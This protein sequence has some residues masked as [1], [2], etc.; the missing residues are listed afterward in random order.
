MKD[1]CKKKENRNNLRLKREAKKKEN[2]RNWRYLLEFKLLSGLFRWFFLLQLSFSLHQ[3]LSLVRWLRKD[4]I[5]AF[6]F[7]SLL[8]NWNR[9][10]HQ[11][12][13]PIAPCFWCIHFKLLYICLFVFFYL[14]KCCYCCCS[15]GGCSS[16]QCAVVVVLL[17]LFFLFL[18]KPFNNTYG[19]ETLRMFPLNFCSQNFCSLTSAAGRTHIWNEWIKKNLTFAY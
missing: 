5:F 13:K 14:V 18:R 17:F 11:F 7:R 19:F 4:I 10:Q 12:T 16:Y 3:H 2:K 6:F 1:A 9:L 8:F 15:S